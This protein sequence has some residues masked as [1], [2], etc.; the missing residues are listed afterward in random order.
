MPQGPS[1]LAAAEPPALNEVM[2]FPGLLLH[3]IRRQRMRAA[4]TA[5]AVAIGVTAVLALGV[6]TTSLRRTAV[7]ILQTGN[8]DFSV[9]QKGASDILYS[10]MS[11]E[12][13]A[14]VKHTP[15]VSRAVG[16][17]ISTAKLNAQHPFF[18][19]IG[20]APNEEA[21]FGITVLDGRSPSPTATNEM[22]LGAQ[23]AKDFGVRVGDTL[24]VE[25]RTFTVVGIMSTGNS[26]GD[27]GGMFP[28]TALQAWHRQPDTYTLVF[29]R[30][31][32]KN[33][34]D[35][36]RHEIET[37]N[38]RLATARSA[39]DYGRVDRNLVL[40]S[41]ANVGGSILAL[42]IGATG[43]MNT[44]LLSF[45]ERIR[46]FG[47]LRALGWSRRRLM[48]LVVGEAFIVAFIGAAAGCALG[49]LAVEALTRVGSLVGVF[50][51]HFG[52][53]IFGRA[54]V[55]AFAMALLGALY[56]ATRAARLAPL[57]ALQ[58]E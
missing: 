52:S 40:I 11:A 44:S 55:F 8:A 12:D 6:L 56:P 31:D 1:A 29:V 13:V 24:K 46:E 45:F 19:E 39:S 33:K 57:T 15:G 43:V 37:A 32:D 53:H 9:S 4:V 51:P 26:V 30:V 18:L 38:P 50:Q 10:T 17:F 7:A 20:I 54:L 48:A 14:A 27:E 28:I 22:M 41:A 58:H 35:A 25:E 42:F 47:V 34:I 21:D 23:A 2:T 5:T 36:V 3:N 49:V 16:V